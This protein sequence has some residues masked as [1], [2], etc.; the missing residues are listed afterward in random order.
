M[1]NSAA[2]VDLVREILAERMARKTITAADAESDSAAIY[3]I[4]RL[5][6]RINGRDDY[7]TLVLRQLQ[8]RLAAA[9]DL[10]ALDTSATLRELYRVEDA[11][12]HSIGDQHG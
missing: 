10:R 2:A 6:A 7:R 11:A 8:T 4:A 3:G 5:S 12:L 9:A 1:D